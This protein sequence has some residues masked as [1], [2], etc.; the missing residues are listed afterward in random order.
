M[1]LY[2]YILKILFYVILTLIRLPRS[3]CAFSN[4]FSNLSFS[5]WNKKLYIYIYIFKKKKLI[6]Y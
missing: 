2:Y 1:D 4:S 6:F 3:S 5:V